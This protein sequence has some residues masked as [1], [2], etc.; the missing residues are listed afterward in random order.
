MTKKTAC[1]GNVLTI[2]CE[3]VSE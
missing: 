3:F 2:A 1:R